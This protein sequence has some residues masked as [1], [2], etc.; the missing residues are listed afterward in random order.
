MPKPPVTLYGIRNCDTV[1]KARQWLADQNVDYR[2]HDF[3]PQ[4]VPIPQ[5]DRW[6]LSVPWETLLN[7][8]GTAWRKLDAVTKASVVNA[9]TARAV[10]LANPSTI[11]RPVV[12]WDGT[13]AGTV[14]V[15]FKPG[16][17]PAPA[18]KTD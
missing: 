18:P 15:G 12:E 8:Q 16:L 6:L 3:K 5:L 1:K 17:W 4:G 2:F 10:M 7:R 13:A 14:T 11:K 9:A